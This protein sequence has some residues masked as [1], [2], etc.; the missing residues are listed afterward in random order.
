M[1]IFTAN[2]VQLMIRFFTF[3]CLSICFLMTSCKD[4][5]ISEVN[6]ETQEQINARTIYQKDVEAIRYTEFGLSTDS[7]E[8]VADWQKF[9]ELNTQIELLKKADLS[10]FA[11]ERL[12]LQTFLSELRAEIPESLKTNEISAR[13]TAVNTKAQ[14]LHSMLTINNISKEQQLQAIKELL[15]TVSNLNLQINKKFEFDK[16]NIVK[17]E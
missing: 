6:A 5:D 1:P 14:K 8:G 16:N 2:C 10:F 3:I 9:H 7:Q 4:G 11:G 12:L 17:P 13:L 15:I